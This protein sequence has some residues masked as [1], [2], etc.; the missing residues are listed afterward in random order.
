LQK[1][2][3]E[4]RKFETEKL[5]IKNSKFFYYDLNFGEKDGD[6]LKVIQF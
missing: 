6:K 3:K 4:E 2:L 1:D 5:D